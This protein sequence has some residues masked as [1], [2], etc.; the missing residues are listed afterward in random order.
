MSEYLL[1]IFKYFF[2]QAKCVGVLFEYFCNTFSG[3]PNVSEY[4]LNTFLVLYYSKYTQSLICMTTKKK[5][6]VE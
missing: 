3:G 2:G 1:N 5:K 6:C 4:F